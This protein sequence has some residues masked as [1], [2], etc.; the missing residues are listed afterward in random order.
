VGGAGR[1]R[2]AHHLLAATRDVR[3]AALQA[4]LDNVL[5]ISAGR[6]LH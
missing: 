2:V 1:A 5:P 6:L 3:L 4:K